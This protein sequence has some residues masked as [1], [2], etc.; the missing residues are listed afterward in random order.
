MA[1]S[2][3]H[4]ARWTEPDNHSLSV[5]ILKRFKAIVGQSEVVGFLR[6]PAT[7]LPVVIAPENTVASGSLGRVK[8]EAMSNG[9]R[10]L[11]TSGGILHTRG[12]NCKGV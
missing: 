11:H 6:H 10:H 7:G 12:L 3:P 4:R 8:S 5:H 1:I 9:R 2:L